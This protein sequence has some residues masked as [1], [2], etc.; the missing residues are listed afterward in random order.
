MKDK[1]NLPKAHERIKAIKAKIED[2]AIRSTINRF[3]Y[4]YRMARAFEG[5]VA[6]DIGKN[7]VEG[8]AVGMRLLLAYGAFDE[9]RLVR[10]SLP[11][12]KPAKG[13]YV[14]IENKKLAEKLR[15]ITELKHLLSLSTAVK[16]PSL[17]KDVENFFNERNNDVMCIATGLRNS[18]AHG[19]FT[20]AGAGLKTK[21]KRSYI[22]EL[23]IT[24]LD[25]TDEI[26]N[27]CVNEYEKA[28]Q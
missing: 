19:V 7:T 16:N 1:H 10:N 18:Y 11:N 13:S 3:Q 26:A 25:M 2:T 9:I 4:R 5:I 22:D 15:K 12:I 24:I 20:A 8:Y 17:Q 27:Q 23:A 14:K 21:T 28:N 6:P